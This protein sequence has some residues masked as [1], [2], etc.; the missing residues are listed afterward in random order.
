MFSCTQAKTPSSGLP[1]P[2]NQVHAP[3]SIVAFTN[4]F[5]IKRIMEPYRVSTRTLLV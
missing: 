4:Y 5:A 2:P 1:G 3:R